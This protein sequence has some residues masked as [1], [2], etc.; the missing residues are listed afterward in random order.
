MASADHGLDQSAKL[1][2]PGSGLPLGRQK[3]HV[4]GPGKRG[5][6]GLVRREPAIAALVSRT[7]DLT[8][9]PGLFGGPPGEPPGASAR[10][11]AAQAWQVSEK[12]QVTIPKML[13]AR[14]G[15]TAGTVLVFEERQGTLVASR[16]VAELSLIHI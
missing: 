9:A 16:A 11:D 3:G 10:T 15:L 8:V 7:G 14:L 12:G 13:R 1:D 5:V 2:D 4:E 6:D